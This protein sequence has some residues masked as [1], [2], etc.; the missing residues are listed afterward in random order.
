MRYDD[1]T[2][3]EL[4]AFHKAREADEQVKFEAFGNKSDCIY[5]LEMYAGDFAGDFD[6]DEAFSD[7]FRYVPSWDC[8][9]WNCDTDGLNEIL[10]ENDLTVADASKGDEPR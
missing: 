7:A 4:V 3:E 10:M 1:M 5:A 6:L 8:F 2:D 9:I